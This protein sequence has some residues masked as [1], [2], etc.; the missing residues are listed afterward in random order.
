M[1]SPT[2]GIV[3]AYSSLQKDVNMIYSSHWKD[4]EDINRFS[5]LPGF[6]LVQFIPVLGVSKYP[7]KDKSACSHTYC[8]AYIHKN[9]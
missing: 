9:F 8:K 4:N 1:R 7:K 5:E 2:E 3:V 6:S